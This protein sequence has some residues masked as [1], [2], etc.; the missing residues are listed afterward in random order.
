MLTGRSILFRS[1][2]M[3]A[4]PE[5]LRRLMVDP[6]TTDLEMH[7]RIQSNDDL[8]TPRASLC[9]S[10]SKNKYFS[11]L[12]TSSVFSEALVVTIL[13]QLRYGYTPN[14]RS[15]TTEYRV[16]K[17]RLKMCGNVRIR[18]A[19]DVGFRIKNVVASL[20][21]MSIAWYLTI[22]TRYSTVLR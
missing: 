20:L 19:E 18:N 22:V 17:M 4:K 15:A 13:S 9:L 3:M 10:I 12:L 1:S 16:S 8:E 14:G 7:L 5:A 2:K 6:Q 11:C 21:M